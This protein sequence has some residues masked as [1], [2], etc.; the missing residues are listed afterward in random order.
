VWY[1]PTYPYLAVNCKKWAGCKQKKILE[2]SSVGHQRKVSRR[3][4]YD[5]EKKKKSI[6][7]ELNALSIHIQNWK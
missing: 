7:C 5:A 1:N 2:K 4:S 6:S 3:S